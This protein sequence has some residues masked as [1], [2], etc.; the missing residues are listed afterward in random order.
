MSQIKSKQIKLVAVGDLLVGG[1]SGNGSVLTKG[2]NNTFLR[3]NASSALAWASIAASEI[4]FTP[5]GGIS[6]TDTQSAVTGL[7]TRISTVEFSTAK[8]SARVASTTNVS[9]T[10]PGVSID[11]ITLAVGDRVL[12][13]NQSIASQ[14]GVYVFQGSASTL[15]RSIDSATWNSLVSQL[16]NV[17]EGTT[18]SDTGWISTADKGGTINT[19]TVAYS[20]FYGLGTYTATTATNGITLSARDFQLTGQA[21]AL[22]QFASNGILVRTGSATF[23]AR[24]I[25]VGT[26]LTVI[27]TDGTAGN[28]TVGLGTELT[29]LAGLSTTGLVARTAAGTYSPVTIITTGSGISIVNGGGVAGAPSLSL[30]AGLSSLSG[31]T[32]ASGT[33]IPVLTAANTY[34]LLT[35]G[36]SAA[37]NILDR[38]S[39]DARYLQLTGGT[40]TGTLIHSAGTATVAPLQ[41]T[42]GI[43]LTTAV[44]GAVE[45]DGTNL[46]IT[47]TTGPTRQILAYLSSPAFTGTPTAPTAAVDTN[48]TQLATTAFVLGQAGSLTPVMNGTAAVGVSTRYS[49]Q[50]HVHPSDTSRSPTASPTFTGTVTI[51]TVI[52]GD[53]SSKAASTAYVA[54]AVANDDNNTVLTGITTIASIKGGAATLPVNVPNGLVA[55]FG[56]PVGVANYLTFTS[57]APCIIASTGS[58]PDA[59]LLL[60]A[61]GPGFVTTGSRLQIAAGFDVI[62]GPVSTFNISP[63]I[64]TV[65]AGDNSVTAASTA[66]VFNAVDAVTSVSVAGATNVSLTAAQSGI[67]TIKLTG[68]I[69]ANIN[70]FVP[71]GSSGRW[72]FVNNTTGA[73]TVTIAYPT[74]SGVV[75]AQGYSAAVYGDNTNVYS[76]TTDYTNLFIQGNPT[77]TTQTASDNSTRIATTAFIKSQAYATIASPTF[78]GTVTLPAGTATAQ[79]IKFVSGTNLTTAVAGS[80]EY[81]GT[82]LYFTPTGTTRQTVAYLTSSITGTATNVTGTVAIANGGTGAVTAP[83]A[84]A[85]LGAV[86]LAGSTM[87]G[88]LI[89][90][91]D[92]TT[93]LQA[94]TKGYVDTKISAL[95]SV[96]DYRGTLAGG[97]T[98]VAAVDLD[99]IAFRNPG[100]YYKVTVSGYFKYVDSGSVSRTFFANL[101]DGIVRNTNT[102]WDVIG[103]TESTIVGTTNRIAVSGTIDTGFSVDIA[104]TYVGQT[105]LT[106]LGT[107][108][109]GVWNGT[110]IGSA[111]GG[112]GSN[113]SALTSNQILIA[114]GSGITTAIIA[115]TT[116]YLRW[117]GSAY[118]WAATVPGA[119]ANVDEFTPAS[120][121]NAAVT[122]TQTP[123]GS[124]SVF[125]NGI[126]L[127]NNGYSLAGTTVTLNDTNVGY[128]VDGTDVIDVSYSY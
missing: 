14:N 114:N 91:A 78:T 118:A 127:K 100:D 128:S 5:A 2:S 27:N 23:A 111:Y 44:A 60:Q 55:T 80:M 18:N 17:D 38:T 77:T 92:P 43:N 3:V 76:L 67:A 116:G 105:S 69:T 20:Q 109:T 1:V 45:F 70:V 98:S 25:A 28:P 96:F 101:N 53:N 10:A 35:V 52:A 108:A 110:I 26:G 74:G 112:T 104:G 125:F 9:L 117:T 115:P 57:G 89:L 46:Y 63:I 21:L 41:F 32:W 65:P 113:L 84:L 90:N 39:A 51:P 64:I 49:R 107:V 75:I 8:Q 68:A 102:G 85:A 79:P 30:A 66:Y 71:A 95:G 16:I 99:A 126:R 119:T 83:L 4:T 54:T 81:D 88:A 12:L 42:A 56:A 34:S 94:S 22:H 97:A 87:T 33:Q 106:T 13:K 61:K 59:S 36:N 82:N 123:V 48:T 58:D 122:L 47:Q 37:S 40:V 120:A 7:D 11:G 103:H 62:S 93:A 124:I 86:A 73:F 31:V 6:A 50:D 121:T 24:S 72:T 19:T 15:T 29:G